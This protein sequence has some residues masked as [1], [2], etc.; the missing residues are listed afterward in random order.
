MPGGTRGDWPGA[1]VGAPCAYTFQIDIILA[2]WVVLPG[3]LLWGASFPLGLA[4]RASKD[5]DLTFE[6]PPTQALHK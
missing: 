6:F 1:S 3:A 5:A 4:A 2:L